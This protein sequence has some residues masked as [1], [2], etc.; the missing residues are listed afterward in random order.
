MSSVYKTSNF[1]EGCALRDVDAQNSL[2]HDAEEEGRSL[3][4]TGGN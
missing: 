4:S 1:L 2:C 3:N